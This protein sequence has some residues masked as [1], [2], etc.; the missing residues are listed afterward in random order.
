MDAKSKT[1]NPPGPSRWSVFRTMGNVVDD[2]LATL[3]ALHTK[4]GDVVHLPLL[5]RNA[6]FINHPDLVEDVLLRRSS[7]F[8]K[9]ILL[10]E[11]K[12]LLGEGLLTSEGDFWKRQRKLSSPFLTR[13][14]IEKYAKDMIDLATQFAQSLVDGEEVDIHRR[15]TALTLDIVTRTLFGTTGVEGVAEQVERSVD[16]TMDHFFRVTRSWRRLIPHWIPTAQNRKTAAAIADLDAIVFRIIEDRREAGATGDDLLSRLLSAAD[17]SGEG[18]DDRQIRDEV[19][20]MFLAGHETT[21][22]CQRV[23]DKAMAV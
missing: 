15:T 1:A 7:E 9:D 17:A 20:T 19:I 16:V 23:F 11:V 8:S 10:R 2:P 13:R 18:M 22:N 4:H 12:L 14:Q 21:D 6:F 3:S 5:F